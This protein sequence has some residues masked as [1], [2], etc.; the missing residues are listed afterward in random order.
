MVA[1]LATA[2]LLRQQ[3]DKNCFHSA[4]KSRNLDLFT[5]V[6]MRL[7]SFVW[8]SCHAMP[9]RPT[10]VKPGPKVTPPFTE[11]WEALEKCVEEGLIKS[12]GVS[13]FSPEKIET[14][15]PGAKIRPAV[16]QVQYRHATSNWH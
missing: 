6:L 12:I 13:N 14:F 16:N 7:A 15:M 2:K 5:T 1:S 4:C 3:Y 9:C 11:T 10:S 8:G